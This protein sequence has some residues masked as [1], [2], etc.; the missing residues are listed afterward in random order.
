MR[1]FFSYR[2]DLSIPSETHL[3]CLIAVVVFQH[4]AKELEIQYVK[5]VK[6]S[7]TSLGSAG[8]GGH[9]PAACHPLTLHSQVRTSGKL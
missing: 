1:A 6:Q 2:S 9:S 8:T 3:E 4:L 5:R 7:R